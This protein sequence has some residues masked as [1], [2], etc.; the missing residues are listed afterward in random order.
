ML[1]IIAKKLGHDVIL[2]RSGFEPCKVK[3]CTTVFANHKNY[4]I[5]LVRA[6]KKAYRLK[7]V[8]SKDKLRDNVSMYDE[9][10]RFLYNIL[11]NGGYVSNG[12]KRLNASMIPEFMIEYDLAVDC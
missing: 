11:K 6:N 3:C 2:L 5:V 10:V 12:R 4:D 9:L 8:D 7:Y 1:N